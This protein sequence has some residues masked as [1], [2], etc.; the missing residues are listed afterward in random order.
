MLARFVAHPW[1][2]RVIVALIL[3][4]AVT[5]GLETFRT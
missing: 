5:L 4:N 3:L 1:T 2:E